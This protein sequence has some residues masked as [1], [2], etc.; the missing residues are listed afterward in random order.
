VLWE[1][2]LPVFLYGHT[3]SHPARDLFI[4]DGLYTR[5]HIV[6]IHYEELDRFGSPRLEILGYHGSD[7]SD[8]PR[9]GH[10][11]HPHCHVSPDGRWIA[12]NRADDGRT[13]IYVL[14]LDN[15]KEIAEA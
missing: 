15:G 12:Y 7:M 8:Y 1:Q 6:A 14:E 11:C 4:S 2:D 13:D 9:Y 10:A 5:D 3:S